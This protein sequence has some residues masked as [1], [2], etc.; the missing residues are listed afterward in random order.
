M[1][2]AAPRP[3]SGAHPPRTSMSAKV[4]PSPAR[5]CT[6]DIYSILN[7]AAGRCTAGL[8]RIASRPRPA[9]ARSRLRGFH[10][11]RL[12]RQKNPA[13]VP[14]GP[15][16]AMVY[17]HRILITLIALL[18]LLVACSPQANGF[19]PIA[20]Q[21]GVDSAPPA[22]QSGAVQA[23]VATSE[24]VVGPNRMA[25]GLIENNVPIPDA[26]QTRVHARFFKLKGEQAV[27]VSEET[28]HYYGQGLG[29][30]GTFITH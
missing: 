6:I 17:R 7:A 5:R 12:Q 26:A 3:P 8:R 1:D 22:A 14:A 18:M 2:G 16:G 28:A 19:G 30:R 9:Y 11:T 24:L 10:C 15:D 21:P 23:V 20:N 4:R 25:L 27:L 29:N 13:P